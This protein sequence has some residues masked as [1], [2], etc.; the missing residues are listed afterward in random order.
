[1]DRKCR[2]VRSVITTG[3]RRSQLLWAA[4]GR[5]S[6]TGRESQNDPFWWH[7]VIMGYRWTGIMVSGCLNR[8]PTVWDHLG[9]YPRMAV[10]A[11]KLTT[12]TTSQQAEST[13]MFQL[14]LPNVLPLYRHCVYIYIYIYTVYIYIYSIYIQ[15]HL[16]TFYIYI[17]IYIYTTRDYSHILEP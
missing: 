13:T 11:R 6:L 15:T 2:A 16:H 3:W 12:Q 1:M 8:S 10:D 17:Y 14:Q 4:L 5:R 7:T 9:N